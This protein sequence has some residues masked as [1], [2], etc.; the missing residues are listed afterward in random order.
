MVKWYHSYISKRFLEIELH[1]DSV[2]LTTG[3]GFRVCSARFWLIAFDKAI[4]I[5][6]TRGITGTGY[7]DDCSALIGGSN[8]DNMMESMQ[9]M[10]EEL[11]AWG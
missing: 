2:Q 8:P 3:T 4:Q 1:G 10:L 9:T 5:I 6:N 7:A 11:V